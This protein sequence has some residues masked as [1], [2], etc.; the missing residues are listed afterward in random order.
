[1]SCSDSSIHWA[2]SQFQT[3]P[4]SSTHPSSQDTLLST[5]ARFPIS[6]KPKRPIQPREPGQISRQLIGLCLPAAQRLADLCLATG[7]VD[8]DVVNKSDRAWEAVLI[9]R[10]RIWAEDAFASVRASIDDVKP[11]STT[12]TPEKKRVFNHEYTPFLEKYF[13]FNA[14]PSAPDRAMLARKSMMSPRQIEVWFQNHRNRAKKEGRALR[15]LPSR[16]APSDRNLA[17][18]TLEKEMP[19]FAIPELERRTTKS[20][21]NQVNNAAHNLRIRSSILFWIL[22]VPP[23]LSPLFT[24]SVRLLELLGKKASINFLLLCGNASLQTVPPLRK[25]LWT[26]MN[27]FWILIESFIFVLH[28]RYRHLNLRNSGTQEGQLFLVRRL[29]LL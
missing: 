28:P 18:E 22:L 15:R 3:H 9:D 11:S 10:T 24:P 23:M 6:S 17:L 20:Q 16:P 7:R 5:L 27:L 1:M 2:L 14:Y 19:Y 4:S 25:R 29:Y 13:D 8:L 12:S 26:Y 21:R